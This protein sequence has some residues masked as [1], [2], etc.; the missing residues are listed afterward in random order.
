[1]RG[2]PD[3]CKPTRVV[4]ATPDS[5]TAVRKRGDFSPVLAQFE[6]AGPLS[7][8]FTT[9]CGAPSVFIAMQIRAQSDSVQGPADWDEPARQF[10]RALES[11]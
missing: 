7:E 1:M 3:P 4:F 10:C 5:K 8:M 2:R 9:I 6:V 11:I